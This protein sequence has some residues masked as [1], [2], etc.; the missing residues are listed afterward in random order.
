M[1]R[2]IA[3]FLVLGVLASVAQQAWALS[4]MLHAPRIFWPKGY[5]QK[6]AEQVQAVLRSDKFAFRGGLI[7]YWEP[8]WSTTVVYGGNT[9]SLNAFMR[10]L[11]RIPGI[12]VKVTL[13]QD[14]SKE[15]GSALQAGSWWVKYSHVT[16]DTLTVRINLASPEIDSE[17][18]D[19]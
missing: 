9:K 12:R 8:Q 5:D 2:A 10:E 16:P 15:T 1:K 7:S 4:E 11:R 18:I 6:K 17:Q 3:L 19:L 14:L 13:S